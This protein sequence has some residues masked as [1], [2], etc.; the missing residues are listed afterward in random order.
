MSKPGYLTTAELTL[1]QGGPADNGSVLTA[2]AGVAEQV[3]KIPTATQNG[4]AAR[5]TIIK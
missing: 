1:V 4:E 5:E 2:V 3:S